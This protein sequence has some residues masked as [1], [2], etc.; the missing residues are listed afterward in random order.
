MNIIKNIVGRDCHV[1]E[2]NRTV[3]KHVISC[4]KNGY[5][6]FQGL[7]KKDRRYFMTQCIKWHSENIK[8]YNMVVSGKFQY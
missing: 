5:K 1:A 4:L 3:I 2:S 8:E 7:S 6:T